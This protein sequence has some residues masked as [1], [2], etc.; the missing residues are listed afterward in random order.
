MHRVQREKK[1]I[2]VFLSV[3]SAANPYIPESEIDKLTLPDYSYER[4]IWGIGKL[5]AGIDEAGRG[6]LA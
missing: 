1:N 5:P 6:P 2:F 4:K 3:F